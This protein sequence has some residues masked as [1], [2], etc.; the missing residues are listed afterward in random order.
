MKCFWACGLVLGLGLWGG[1]AVA[2][3]YSWRPAPP[4]PAPNGTGAPPA[5]APPA[6]VLGR[7]V[8]VAP[9][10]EPAAGAVRPVG[11]WTPEPAPGPVY[12]AQKPDPDPPALPPA[13]PPAKAKKDT[14]DPPAKA[15]KVPAPKHPASGP[16]GNPPPNMP[17]LLPAPEVVG[18]AGPR[19]AP[20]RPAKPAKPAKRVVAATGPTGRVARQVSLT[21]EDAEALPS[22]SPVLPGKPLPVGQ[23]FPP[24]GPLPAGAP[25]P[26]ADADC[27]A[28]GACLPACPGSACCEGE[29]CPCCESACP[30]SRFY[31]SAEYLL[32]ATKDAHVPILATT[33]PTS[34][35]GILGKNGT[36]TLFG[37]DSALDFEEQSGGRVTAGY[38]LD[39]CQLNGIEG[40]AFFLAQ[41]SLN[42]QATT[43]EFP[44]LSRPFFNASTGMQTAQITAM[45]GVATG[46]ITVDAQ[47][48]LWGA[49]AD[50]RHNLLCGCW[51]RLDSLLGFR[52]VGL[53]EGLH[54]T[55]HATVVPGIEKEFP[56]FP[57]PAGTDIVVH[58]SFNTHNRFYGAQLGLDGELH[59]GR[60]SLDVRGT[61]ALGDMHQVVNINGYQLI[62]PPNAPAQSFQGG[63]LALNSNSGHHARNTFAV[64]PEVG[65]T[66][67]YQ[68][69]DKVRIFAGYNFLFLSDVVRPG[70]QIDTVLDARR[71]PN[72][73]RLNPAEAK[74]PLVVPPRP[75]FQ[76][77]ETSYWA[78]GLTTGLEFKY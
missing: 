30:L 11:F 20:A 69:T 25:L 63:L 35:L 75:M 9:A 38:W 29:C 34:S 21:V 32:W 77:H 16:G 66:L 44:L 53:D 58:D 43:N 23:P 17:A 72:F 5:A 62:I 13:D 41:R 48:S 8:P 33:G 78:Q 59:H 54:V 55:E 60:W 71:I 10:T 4:P 18:K 57:F 42:F 49:Q 1:V 15:K 61:V 19:T 7:P 73:V 76:F 65:V 37:G 28:D 40:S 27:C 51:Y 64:V 46:S 52:V 2:Q 68:L 26:Q 67:G 74:L 6:A 31:G 14:A 12:R 3:E 50:W 47:T 39:A 56:G 70:D 22:P 36:R 45:P 24:G